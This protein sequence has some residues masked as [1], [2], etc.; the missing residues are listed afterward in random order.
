MAPCDTRVCPRSPD[1]GKCPGGWN[2]WESR[3]GV[4]LRT[5]TA[6]GQAG[7]KGRS[8]PRRHTTPGHHSSCHQALGTL[9]GSFGVSHAPSEQYHPGSQRSIQHPLQ[10]LLPTSGKHAIRPTAAGGLGHA[11]DGLN[12]WRWTEEPKLPW[13][14]T[15]STQACRAAAK[16]A[17]GRVGAVSPSRL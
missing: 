6:L 17:T 14:L 11:G 8:P 12:R 3:S 15:A 4:L 5:G 7:C 16:P 1:F 10:S 9:G 13:S 2:R